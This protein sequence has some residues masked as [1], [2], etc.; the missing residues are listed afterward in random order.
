MASSLPPPTPAMP[1]RTSSVA[2]AGR[3]L[4]YH[5]IRP[6]ASRPAGMAQQAQKRTTRCLRSASPSRRLAT[7]MPDRPASRNMTTVRN[8]SEGRNP[9]LKNPNSTDW[10]SRVQRPCVSMKVRMPLMMNSEA[11]AMTK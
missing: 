9:G 3:V 4:Q 6:G 10:F 11:Q 5:S 2:E 8:S 7:R 1:P